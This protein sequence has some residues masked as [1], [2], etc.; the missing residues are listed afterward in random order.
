[1]LTSLRFNLV[2]FSILIFVF[3]NG[4]KSRSPG[5]F[6]CPYGWVWEDDAW[7]Y[8]INRAVDEKGML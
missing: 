8:D 7:I 6:E 1:M 4:E 5:E 3:Q 2:Q